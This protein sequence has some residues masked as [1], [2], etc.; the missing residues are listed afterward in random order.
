LVR[1]EWA[2]RGRSVVEGGEDEHEQD[3]RGGTQCPARD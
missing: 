1:D 2:R 3:E